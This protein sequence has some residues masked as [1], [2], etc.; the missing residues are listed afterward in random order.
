MMIKNILFD[1]DGVILDS[2]P[3][4]DYG[5]K[6]IFEDFDDNLVSKLLEYHNLN[7]GLSRYVKIKYFYNE[8]LNQEISEAEINRYSVLFSALMKKQLTDKKY[9]I[10]ETVKFIRGNYKKYNLHIVSGSDEEEL[11]YLCKA[12]KIDNYFLS[13]N[14]SPTH[15][16]EIVKDVLVANQYSANETILIGDSVNDYDAAEVNGLKFYGYNN[17]ALIDKSRKYLENYVELL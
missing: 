4:R 16:N 2:M 7:G 5:F 11:R 14:G 10:A 8:L 3:I 12:L 13:I 15:K 6:K 1:F 17:P 9:L